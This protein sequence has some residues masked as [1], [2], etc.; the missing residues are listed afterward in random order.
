MARFVG[1]TFT[2]TEATDWAAGSFIRFDKFRD[3]IGANIEWFAQTHKHDGTAGG[4]GTLV[5]ADPKAIIFYGP[6]GNPIA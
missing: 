1:T 3:Q 6:Q 5:T 2:I 4:G